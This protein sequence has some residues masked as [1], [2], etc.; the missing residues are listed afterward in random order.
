MSDGPP[1]T[2]A[3]RLDRDHTEALITRAVKAAEL[4][5]DTAERY[6][7]EAAAER[8]AWA[9]DFLADAE[10]EAAGRER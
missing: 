2:E 3:T 9:L 1:A 8:I 7:L 6:G 4:A 10:Q 5:K